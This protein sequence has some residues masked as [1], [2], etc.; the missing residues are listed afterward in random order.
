MVPDW[1]LSTLTKN[2]LAG[3]Y[4][5]R[6]W[7]IYQALPCSMQSSCYCFTINLTEYLL[8]SSVVH[9]TDFYAIGQ[10]A[11]YACQVDCMIPFATF[12]EIFLENKNW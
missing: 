5:S 6:S 10:F 8:L 12:C 9:V 7:L 2:W 3:N 4:F 1:L 11:F